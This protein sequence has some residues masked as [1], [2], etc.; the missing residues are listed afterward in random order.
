MNRNDFPVQVFIR[1]VSKTA[2]TVVNNLPIKDQR[3]LCDGD[4]I[5]IGQ[6]AFIYYSDFASIKSKGP[7][8]VSNNFFLYSSFFS[9]NIIRSFTGIEIGRSITYSI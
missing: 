3:Q 2:E 4:T 1:S 7:P 6:R 8:S 5:M 9:R